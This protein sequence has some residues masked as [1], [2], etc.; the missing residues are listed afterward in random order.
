MRQS[1]ADPIDSAPEYFPGSH[2]VPAKSVEFGP[3]MRPAGHLVG[4]VV[5]ALQKYPV[6]Q[7]SH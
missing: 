2:L 5:P 4:V 1:L 6:G 7:A 3:Q